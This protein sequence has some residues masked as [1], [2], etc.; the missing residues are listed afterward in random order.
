MALTAWEVVKV[1]GRTFE[2]LGTK[3]EDF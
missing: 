2:E 3:G 1:L